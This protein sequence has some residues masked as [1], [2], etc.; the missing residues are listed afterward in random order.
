MNWLYTL[1]FAG[2]AFSSQQSPVSTFQNTT[3]VQP[4]IESAR[5]DETERFEQ[6]YPFS[7]NG[8]VQV[9]NVNGSITVEGWDKNEIKLVYIKSGDSKERLKDV[10][11][12]IDARQDSF[13]VETDYGNWKRENGGW[14][15]NGKVTVE[16]QLMVPRG[17]VLNE[18]ETVNGSVAI[19]GFTN[20]VS[21]S[22]VNGSVN[23][24]NI[25]GTAR[26]STV[27]GE[28]RA[29]FDRLEPGS[30]ISLETVNGKANLVIP[31][32][33]SATVRAE[34]V[35]G[36]I[37]NDF[38]LPVRKGKY[39]GRDLYGRLGSGDVQ[40][41]LESVNGA[42]TISRKN[43]GRTLSPATDLLPQKGN[44]DDDDW[45]DDSGSRGVDKMNKEIDRS[46]KES[47]KEVQKQVEKMQP[48]IGR[49]TEEAVKNAAKAIE[50]T[51]QYLQSEEFKQ[52]LIEA[53]RNQEEMRSHMADAFFSTTVPRIEKRSGT[54]K[55]K[56]SPKVTVDAKGC[57]VIV[58]GSDTDEVQYRVIQYSNPRQQSPVDIKEEHTD[59]TVKLTV[60]NPDPDGNMFI[61]PGRVRI[62]IS[63]PKRSDLKIDTDGE[64]RIE[65]VSGDLQLTGADESINV[66]DA[67]GTLHVKNADGRV[68]VLGFRGQV[69]A[70]TGD[71]NIS[72]EGAFDA[73]TA[74]AG[75]GDIT[76]TLPEGAGAEV[77]SNCDQVQGEGVNL[78]RRDGD[79]ERSHYKVGRGGSLFRV[80]SEGQ[81]KIRSMSTLNPNS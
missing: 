30:K 78:T 42:L 80:D 17:A 3:G 33:S 21:V 51:G 79:D 47:A 52:S 23:A 55:V 15:N 12:R 68:R 72:L 18:I 14:K 32:D 2:L 44:D 61:G 10:D 50:Q 43:D 31:S 57:S 67:D 25:R 66:R 7:S 22:A 13:E 74:R 73:L 39:V 37:S 46:V 5:V 70:Q 49:V 28:S 40:I 35:N 6:T 53:R 34:S 56:G 41:K 26:L 16:F 58:R 65:G 81:I 4:V 8:R 9:S 64:I 38:G 48:E 60:R 75:G 24:T 54:F 45:D 36:S 59:K 29:E 62:E 27:N 77:D 63:V 1:V 11:V 71:G 20:K 19:S 69:D 76:I